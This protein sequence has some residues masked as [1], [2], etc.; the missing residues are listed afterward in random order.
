M[1]VAGDDLSKLQNSD[2]KTANGEGRL[3]ILHVDDDQGFLEV[4]KSL[5]EL[6]GNF[7]VDNA[8]SVDEAFKKLEEQSYAAVISDYEMPQKNGL[9]FLKE[10]REQ[11]TKI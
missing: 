6:E 10:L 4:S 11:K 9:D 3:H 7:E 5:L 2:S 8:S 1:I